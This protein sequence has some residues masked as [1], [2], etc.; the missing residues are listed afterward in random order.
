MAADILTVVNSTDREGRDFRCDERRYGNPHKNDIQ[1]LLLR[2]VDMVRSE[3]Y[4]D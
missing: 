1:L 2:P 4:G 3:I